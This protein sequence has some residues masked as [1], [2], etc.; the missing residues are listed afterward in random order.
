MSQDRE[1]IHYLAVGGEMSYV[2]S[3][4]T[5][6]IRMKDRRS[7]SELQNG[8]TAK[9]QSLLALPNPEMDVVQSVQRMLTRVNLA[10]ALDNHLVTSKD[11]D[12]P[13]L[14]RIDAGE[15]EIFLTNSP[16]VIGRIIVTPIFGQNLNPTQ[17]SEYIDKIWIEIFS[18]SLFK[19]VTGINLNRSGVCEE[20]LECL[21][22]NANI[23]ALDFSGCQ[24]GDKLIQTLVK[25]PSLRTL[26]LHHNRLTPDGI[27]N[28]AVLTNLIN[29]DLS[30]NDVDDSTLLSLIGLEN[31]EYLNLS[32]LNSSGRT[33]STEGVDHLSQ[34]SKLKFLD[35]SYNRQIGNLTSNQLSTLSNLVWLNLS[36]NDLS[37]EGVSDFSLLINLKALLL[38]SNHIGM[39]GA[40]VIG[41]LTDLTRLELH[42]N[43]IC[44]EG[45]QSLSKLKNLR[46][47]D[48]SVNEI[49]D[50]GAEVVAGFKNLRKLS[51]NNNYITREGVENFPQLFSLEELSIRANSLGDYGAAL[52]KKMIGLKKLE[53]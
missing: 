10:W 25:M 16:G 36:A 9:V 41:E 24:M 31:L 2:P 7:F 21:A 5:D 53:I 40:R 49:G 6:T 45:A 22:A 26:T 15:V 14:T 34:L 19:N 48:L 32:N 3:D 52:L 35:L 33:I 30:W 27:K 42:G 43:A 51:L 39:E 4:M 18:S 23:E 13:L 1:R 8:L 28:L 47:L 11:L 17:W 38:N 46:V 44:S 50:V 29:L 12:D 20:A 37:F